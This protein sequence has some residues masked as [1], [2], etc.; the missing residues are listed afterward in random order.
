MGLA[1][2]WSLGLMAGGLHLVALPL[3]GAAVVVYAGFV[4]ALGLWLSTVNRST[5]RATLFTLL[6][7]LVCIAGPGILVKAAGV[8]SLLP[9]ASG[10]RWRWASLFLDYGLTPPASI[11]VLTFR[12]ADFAK[13]HAEESV[14]CIV[15]ALAGL[16]VYLMA[17][18]LLGLAA[19]V[20]LRAEKGPT[21]GRVP[22]SRC[23]IDT[24]PAGLR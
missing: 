14:A 13:D 17:T 23:A 20:R 21:P 19:R 2:L 22:S 1:V 3:L 4:A 7:A 8:G 12:T 18:V 6:A 15:S 11:W 9:A 5:L 16:H 10:G 24:H